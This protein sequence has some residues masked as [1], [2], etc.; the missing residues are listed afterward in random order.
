MQGRNYIFLVF[1]G[2]LGPVFNLLHSISNMTAVN[3][4]WSAPFSLNVT[5]SD[6]DIRYCVDI[7]NSSSSR[8]LHS[9]CDINKTHY[10]WEYIPELIACGWYEIQVK[11][12]NP[13]GNS[14]ASNTTAWTGGNSQC[15]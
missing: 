7:F 15:K 3:I 9:D 12:F 1:A 5:G 4:F 8:L 2:I 13:V 11:A 6:I 14:T 10:S